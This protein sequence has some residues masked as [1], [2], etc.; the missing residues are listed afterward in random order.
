MSLRELIEQCQH[1]PVLQPLAARLA[2]NGTP[3]FIVGGPVRDALD[4]APIDDLDVATAADPET[5]TRLAHDLGDLSHV[6]ASFG[7]IKI[8]AGEEDLDVATF[9]TERYEDDSRNPTVSLV[10]DIAT[11]LQRRD[12]TINA[13]AIRLDDGTLVDPYD[14]QAALRRR[15][16]DT[17]ADPRVSFD[18]DPLR[19]HR[20]WRFAAT[21]QLT[22]APRLVAA[23]RAGHSRLAVLPRERTTAELLKVVDHPA[24]VLAAAV[25]AMCR[26]GAHHSALAEARAPQPQTLCGLPDGVARL[27][28]LTQHSDDSDRTLRTWKI[29]NDR[30]RRTV[31]VHKIV[32][33]LGSCDEVAARRMVRHH[34]DDQLDRAEALWRVRGN[35]SCGPLATARQRADVWRQPLAVTGADLLEHQGRSPGPWVGA[36]LRDLE[37][38][39][40]QT[41]QNPTA[42][43]LTG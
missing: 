35:D 11:D 39:L 9:R 33:Q 10:R 32:G 19:I 2:T 24:D 37:T 36:A 3:L 28:A 43:Q 26:L 29:D 13:M 15:R 41:G 27:A 42:D 23:A 21:R 4:G 25:E 16:L 7:V 22:I 20:A 30:R 34:D 12:F 17:P 38:S 40:V 31:A 6:G 8:G 18:D 1:H 5:I 14:G